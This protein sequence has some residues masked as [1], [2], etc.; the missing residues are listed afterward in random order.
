[1]GFSPSTILV[2]APIVYEDPTLEKD[3]K[4]LNYDEK[5]HG[6]ISMRSAL[7]YSRNV[8][9]IRLLE[10]VGTRG[11]IDFSQRVGIKNPL[12]NDL[13]VALGSSSVTLHELTSVFGIFANQG[14]KA[15]SMS[16]KLI[17]TREGKVLL[18]ETEAKSESVL[19]KETAYLITNMFEDVIQYGTGQRAK[20]LGRQIAGKTGTTNEFTDAWFMGYTPNLVVGVW[21]GYDDRKSLGH[22]EAGAQPFQSG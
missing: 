18:E 11:V 5:F 4:P 20:V 9:T 15:E 16:I 2:D 6:F 12:A 17:T 7:A 13:S 8:A 22:G 19:S 3:W 21:V 14:I 10:K 1:M